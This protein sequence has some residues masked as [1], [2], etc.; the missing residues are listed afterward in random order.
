M[1]EDFN[2]TKKLIIDNLERYVLVQSNKEHG[3]IYSLENLTYKKSLINDRGYKKFISDVISKGINIY[4]C[5]NEIPKENLIGTPCIQIWDEGIKNFVKIPMIE[6]EKKIP[7]FW[8][9]YNSK[10]D[11]IR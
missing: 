8:K 9:N 1:I 3:M 11:S 7:L 6:F 10:T 2:K 5:I 4:S